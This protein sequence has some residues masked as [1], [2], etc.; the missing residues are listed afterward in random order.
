MNDIK[1]Y[2]DGVLKYD[3]NYKN[4]QMKNISFHPENDIILIIFADN[5]FATWCITR[6]EDNDLDM[7]YSPSELNFTQ[8]V[9]TFPDRAVAFGMI[10]EKEYERVEALKYENQKERIKEIDIK[11]YRRILEAEG[12]TITTAGKENAK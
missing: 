7:D 8:V 2:N 11:R 12:Y 10:T 3:A 6:D 4:K 9:D 1:Y 5:T